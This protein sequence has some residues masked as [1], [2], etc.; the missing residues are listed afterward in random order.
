MI[1]IFRRLIKDMEESYSSDPIASVR[2]YISCYDSV[3][4]FEHVSV[5][6]R[7]SHLYVYQRVF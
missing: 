7:E 4:V 2:I 1:G 3:V 5:V 6:R